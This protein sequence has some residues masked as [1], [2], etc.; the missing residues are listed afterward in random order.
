MKTVSRGSEEL[1]AAPSA[2]SDLPV[3]G[4]SE[5]DGAVAP[6]EIVI[7]GSSVAEDKVGTRNR[8]ARLILSGGPCTAADLAR[9]LGLTPAAVR[10]HLDALLAEGLVEAR[11]Q[12]IYGHRGRGR[13]A[14]VFVLTGPGRAVFH[15]AYDDL[16]ADALRFIAETAGEQAV[17]AFAR[18]RFDDLAAR[19]GAA[20]AAAAPADRP[21]LLAEALTT[22]GYA[23]SVRTPGVTQGTAQKRPSQNTQDITTNVGT[24]K[25]DLR[26]NQKTLRNAP[27]EQLCQHHCPV[28]HV[29]EQFPQ[30][31]EAE[32]QAFAELLGTHVQRLATIAHG[33]GVCTTFIPEFTPGSMPHPEGDQA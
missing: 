10:R 7:D 18:R 24:Q 14:K 13:P 1:S 8:V 29:A 31:C 25:A 3:H 17:E 6:G 15:H 19:Y 5:P 30:L 33:D 2:C 16:A 28:Q 21:R 4:S 11:E 9:Q 32:T 20:L 12:R 23:A 26:T 22:D 27:G